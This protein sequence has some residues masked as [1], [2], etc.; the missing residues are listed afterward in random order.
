[1]GESMPTPGVPALANS[2]DDTTNFGIDYFS[3]L[4]NDLSVALKIQK[5]TGDVQQAGSIETQIVQAQSSLVTLQ[6]AI[7]GLN[8]TLG[9]DLPPRW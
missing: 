6:Q 2:F 3:G 1:M 8:M 9:S 4:L 7:S 5:A